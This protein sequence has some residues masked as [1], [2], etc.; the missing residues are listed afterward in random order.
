MSQFRKLLVGGALAMPVLLALPADATTVE[1]VDFKALIHAADA[2]VVGSVAGSRTET[3]DGQVYTVTDFT[4]GE[5][6]FGDVGGVISVRTMGGE[7]TRSM[8]PVSEVVPGAPRFLS[9]QDY[10]LLLDD[11]P[12]L[13]PGYSAIGATDGFVPAGVFEGA[14]PMVGG[15]V[16]L[17]GLGNGLDAESALEIVTD[18]RAAPTAGIVETEQ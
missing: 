15:R 3:V 13:A 18:E 14:L 7:V 10:F 5:V 17:P 12:S 2:C 1:A 11:A 9:G 8:F 6:G 4:V 16:N